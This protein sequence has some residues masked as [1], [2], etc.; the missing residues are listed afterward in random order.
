MHGVDVAQRRRR[1]S[2]ARSPVLAP[3]KVVAGTFDGI[4]RGMVPL[5]GLPVDRMAVDERGLARPVE[6]GRADQE[7]AEAVVVEVARRG[8]GEP[9][10]DQAGGPVK[11]MAPATVLV[12]ALVA[13][14][15]PI[16]LTEIW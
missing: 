12:G 4:A 10:L 5:I 6:A 1:G 11:G 16:W 15:L 9:G 2:P 3:T 8:D 14:G 13:F 7:V